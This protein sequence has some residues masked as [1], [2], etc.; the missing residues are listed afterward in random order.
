MKFEIVGR[1]AASRLWDVYAD[2]HRVGEIS[3]ERGKWG[4]HYT[5]AWINPPASE[6]AVFWKL[7]NDKV[8]VLNLTSRLLR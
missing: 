2:H 6:E 8:T 5:A 4:F 7:V 3:H 1:I